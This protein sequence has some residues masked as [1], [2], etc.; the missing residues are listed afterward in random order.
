[1]WIKKYNRATFAF[2][3]QIHVFF[4]LKTHQYKMLVGLRCLT[5]SQYRFPIL[6]EKAE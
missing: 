6:L 3:S 2:S 1:M 5:L 4:L